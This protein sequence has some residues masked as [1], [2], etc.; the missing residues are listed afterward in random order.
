M[1]RGLLAGVCV[2]W[3]MT[4]CVVA[5][6]ADAVAPANDNFANAEVVGGALPLTVAGTTVG[7]TPEA[8]EPTPPRMVPD[9]H[10]IW[11]R[12]EAPATEDISVSVCGDEEQS[13]LTAVYTGSTLGGL[14]E[15]ADNN[16]DAAPRA[17][18]RGGEQQAIFMARAGVVYSIWVDSGGAWNSPEPTDG[19]GGIELNL[20]R[21][22]RPSNDDFADAESLLMEEEEGFFVVREAAHFSV[23]NWGATKEGGEP[24][25]RG[26]QGGASVWFEWTATRS[27]GVFVQSYGGL[28]S[29]EPLLAVYTGA[30]VSTLTA[31]PQI[32]S[33]PNYD[34]TF[35]AEA[36][37]TYRIAV[38]G[39]F[40]A[41]ADEA[42]MFEINGSL[43]YVPGNDD[44][45]DAA[46]LANPLTGE[47]D[48]DAWIA[49]FGTVGATK[50]PGEPDHAGNPG[51]H[52]V[53]F[54]WTAPETGS[55]QLLACQNNF[56]T[57][58]A[59]YMG[60]ELTDLTPVA[61]GTNEPNAACGKEGGVPGEAALNIHDGVTYDIAVDGADGTW[62]RFN[63]GIEVSD[64]RLKPPRQ[65][66]AKSPSVDS[67]TSTSTSAA[68]PRTKI[69]GRKVDPAARSVTF[70]LGADVP[71]STFRCKLDN[72]A[73]K[74][75]GTKVTYRHLAFGHHTFRA[76][77]VGP[78]G[79][80]DKTPV[81]ATFKFPRPH[82]PAG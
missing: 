56:P 74:S 46:E 75:C 72:H 16:D 48:T 20:S 49:G 52:S 36:G 65:P 10:S 70:R 9:G 30:S 77:A 28:I 26:N 2:A 4:L 38:D 21:T 3:A 29:D 43:A 54:E 23:D 34:Y 18:C 79:L 25:H 59:V 24:D 35:L 51:G 41:A 47:P 61:S 5:S 63:F 27:G 82:H 14:T 76:Y 19:E 11:F 81:K 44:F 45:E 12:W 64:E 57:L 58:L 15:V 80:R 6:S 1:R 39:A 55:V 42:D 17:S 13:V 50:Q 37:T 40:R 67:T 62:G 66:I 73:Y 22:P 53:W 33:N 31:V 69:A 68:R 78:G 8:G 7:A 60:S 32:E 71:G